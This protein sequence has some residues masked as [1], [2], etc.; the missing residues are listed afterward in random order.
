[1]FQLLTWLLAYLKITRVRMTIN[2]TPEFQHRPIGSVLANTTLHKVVAIPGIAVPPQACGP[3]PFHFT[4]WTVAADASVAYATPDG[5]SAG[6]F[7]V[8]PCSDSALVAVPVA[9][10]IL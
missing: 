3:V 5:C 6:N 9:G 2:A 1:M 8:P 4:D 10:A 7:T